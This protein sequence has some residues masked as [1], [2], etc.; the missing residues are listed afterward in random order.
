MLTLLAKLL[1]A[2]N[3]E[4]SSRQIAAA[5]SLALFFGLA[6]LVSLQSL[7][8]IFLVLFIRVHIASFILAATVFSGIGFLLSP[9]TIAV[10]ENLLTSNALNGMFYLFY[11]FDLFKLFHLHNTYNLG[12]WVVGGVV[13]IMGYFPAKVLVDKYRVHIKAFFEKLYLVR[14]LKA[15]KVFRLYSQFSGQGGLL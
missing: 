11:Q 14:A 6:P 9:V 10:G 2:L 5:V 13:G 4:N 12:A 7:L 1:Q 15:T 8:V 3:S